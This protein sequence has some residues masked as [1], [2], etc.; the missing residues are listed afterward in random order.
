MRLAFFVRSAFAL[1]LWICGIVSLASLPAQGQNLF[2]PGTIIPVQLNNSIS[3]KKGKPGQTFTARVM[4]DVPLPDRGKI[5]AGAKV[6][7]HVI[8]VDP[9]KNG[10]GAR[11]A[12]KIDSLVVR[13]HT[14]PIRIS[15]RAIASPL[16]VE[17]AQVPAMGADRGTLPDS[18]VTTQIGGD[19]VYRGGGHVERHGLVVGEPAPGGVL[20]PVSSNPEGQ[21]RGDVAGNDAPQALWV[22]STDACGV[23]GYNEAEIVDAGRDNPEGTII[24]AVKHGELNIRSGSGLL[25]RVNPVAHSPFR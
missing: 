18:Y 13:H 7:G 5:R 20:A 17:D 23:Y 21:C 15:L 3:S 25:L 1:T 8:Q 10:S 2:P 16:D 4:Q 19:V 24:L 9:P 22:F 12:L 11:V 6:V 14:I